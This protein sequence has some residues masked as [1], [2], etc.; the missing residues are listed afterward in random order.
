MEAMGETF[1]DLLRRLRVRAG[2]SQTEQAEELCHLMGDPLK[3]VTRSEISRYERGGRVPR[4]RMV[5]LYA[6]S[7][8][9][10]EGELLRAA[11][12]A[13][14]A[15]AP[16]LEPDEGIELLEGSVRRRD[17]VGAA[18]LGL[19]LASEPWGRL[20]FALGR[21]GP[22]DSQIAA[23]MAERT[24]SLFAAEEHLPARQLHRGLAEQLDQLTVLLGA[25]G[26]HR[27]SL[28]VSAGETAALAGWLAY[29][30]GDL[31]TARHY[32]QAATQAGHEA[33]HSPLLALVLAYTSYAVDDPR[34]ARD[35]LRAAQQH[36]RAP[37]CA[38]ARAWVSAR[39]AEESAAIGDREGALR[40]LE[41][42]QAVYDYA[43][44][45]EEQ[46]WV[47]FLSKARLDS[48]TVA[49]Y[50]RIDH[51]DL[52]EVSEA[53]L[54]AL[55]PEDAKVRAVILGDVATAY[56]VRGELDRGTEVAREAM[57]VTL[58]SEATLGR[59]RLQALAGQLPPSIA[60]RQL[61]DEVR[62]IL[63]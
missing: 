2:R 28:L 30:M 51:P 10:P 57:E 25:G 47:R 62:A 21:S 5:R 63:A 12:N 23:S 27:R 37:G 52:G 24:A 19:G 14:A 48:M 33:Q 9:V 34:E 58:R 35:L 39:E 3:S 46:P 7:F 49:A 15:K 1:G 20:S 50:A 59:Q 13:R 61:R 56:V 60:G 54:R 6:T 40:A 32:Y 38:T 31:A 41:R 4:P 44:P 36:V 42:A 26:Q 8:G 45:E 17:F 11:A 43:H 22:A 53:A 55:R 29:D 16:V 18:A